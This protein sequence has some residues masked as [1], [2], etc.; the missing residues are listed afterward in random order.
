MN[1]EVKICQS[2]GMPMTEEEQFGTN[3]DGTKN[4]EYCKYC[5][6][7]GS[8]G[9]D[10]TLEEMIESCAP[11]M[12]QEG[13]CKTIEEAKEMLKEYLPTLKRWRNTR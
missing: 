2:C 12:V 11:F 1:K 10:E 9:K 4:E 8:F 13:D 5:Y 7:N 3:A 6:S